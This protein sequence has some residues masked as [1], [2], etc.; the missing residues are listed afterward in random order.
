[1]FFIGHAASRATGL[2]DYIDYDAGPILFRLEG[3]FGM[4]PGVVP[5]WRLQGV[6][7]LGGRAKSLNQGEL[8]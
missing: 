6:T 5:A 8:R 1:V 4:K 3:K 7:I 2:R